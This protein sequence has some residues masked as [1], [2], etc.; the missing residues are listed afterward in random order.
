MD[1]DLIEEPIRVRSQWNG[2]MGLQ[3]I[4]PHSKNTLK[5]QAEESTIKINAFDSSPDPL[6]EAQMRKIRHIIKKADLRQGHRLLEIGSGTPEYFISF[7][8]NLTAAVWPT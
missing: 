3:R 5:Q 8:Q 1:A 7:W 2:G 4:V 6:Y